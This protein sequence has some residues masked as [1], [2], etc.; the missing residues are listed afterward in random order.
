[1]PSKC[2]KHNLLRGPSGHCR[3][4][5]Q[6]HAR[7]W[8]TKYPVRS[9]VLLARK[10]AKRRKTKFNIS[11]KD[12]H[13]PTRCPVLGIPLFIGNRQLK[14]NSPTIDEIIP[15]KGYVKGNVA[16]ISWRANRLK[17]DAT[18]KEIRRVHRYMELHHA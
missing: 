10:R 16:V 11:E 6:E 2:L 12:I 4:C 14:D 13:I 8:R 3:G 7:H 15:G 17:S 18:L 9:L 1:M 5:Q